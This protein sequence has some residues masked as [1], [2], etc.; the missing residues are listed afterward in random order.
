MIDGGTL[1]TAFVLGAMGSAHCAGMC[2]GIGASLGF[3]GQ[4]NRWQL[5]LGYNLGRVGMYALLGAI[6][7]TASAAA[8]AALQPSLP[9]L[10]PW[11]RTL[12]SL[13]VIAMGL[14]VGGWWLGLRHVEAGGAL[15]WRH[16][17]PWAQRWLRPRNTRAAVALGAAW[18][19]LPCGLVYSSLVWAGLHADPLRGAALMAAFGAGTL[20][21]MIFAT[22][23]GNVLGRHL[24]RPVVRRTAGALL[25]AFGAIGAVLPWRHA[26]DHGREHAAPADSAAVASALNCH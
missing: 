5:A 10:L 1:T 12:A 3:A 22:S 24:R 20:P 25:L 7:G 9:M 17:R 19:L 23:C 11:L 8:G 26:L 2:G 21:A 14:Y 13:L 18:G 6:A 16:I 15:L 4:R